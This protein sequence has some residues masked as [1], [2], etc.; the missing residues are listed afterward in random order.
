MEN[1]TNKRTIVPRNIRTPNRESVIL[2]R[3]INAR[4]RSAMM[5][6][7]RT[8]WDLSLMRIPKSSSIPITRSTSRSSML[9]IKPIT[10]ED[11]ILR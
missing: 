4:S 11:A 2:P 9:L 6:S 10:S 5:V 3:E 8:V 7:S 1:N